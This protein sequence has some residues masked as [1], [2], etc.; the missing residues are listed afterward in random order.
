MSDDLC[1]RVGGSAVKAL[2]LLGLQ[3]SSRLVKLPTAPDRPHRQAVRVTT[4]AQGGVRDVTIRI[5]L[6]PTKSTAAGFAWE[7]RVQRIFGEVAEELI[8]SGVIKRNPIA[9]VLHDNLLAVPGALVTVSSFVPASAAPLTADRWGETLALLHLI[10]ATLQARELMTGRPAANTLT[11]LH[12]G[13]FALAVQRP[14]HPLRGQTDLVLSFA[15]TMRER[16]MHALL[17]D[18]EP[19]LA[20][21]DLHALNCISTPDGGMAI[22]WQEASWGNR[23]GDFAWVYLQVKRFGGSP[24]LLESAR[25]AYSRVSHDCPTNEQIAASGHVRELVL[26]G[27]SMQNAYKSLAHLRE[28]LVELPVLRDAEA[29]T[30]PWQLLFNPAVFEPGLVA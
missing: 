23:S 21:R 13:M 29:I 20:H 14:D 17:L 1:Q 3:P 11:G 26:L 9:P 7:Q 18:P 16:A 30:A 25:R 2:G 8:L 5:V 6:D 28:Y 15:R 12:A 10:G 22:D 19:V 24:R 27:Y 4:T